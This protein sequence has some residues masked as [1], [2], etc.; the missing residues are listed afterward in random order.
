MVAFI[1]CNDPEIK[2]F[3]EDVSVYASSPF[4]KGGSGNQLHYLFANE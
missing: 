2:H 3:S 1:T 4:E